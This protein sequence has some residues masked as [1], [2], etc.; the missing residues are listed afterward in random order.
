MFSISLFQISFFTT[1]QIKLML[2]PGAINNLCFLLT[3]INIE[4]S[5]YELKESHILSWLSNYGVVESNI[6]EEAVVLG[7]DCKA[8]QVGTGTYLSRVSLKRRIPNVVPMQGKKIR[9]WYQG[10]KIQCRTCYGHHKRDVNCENKISFV[11]Y[12]SVFR[13]CRDHMFSLEES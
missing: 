4:G 3:F 6:E 11:S 10:V 2:C 5:N 1:I 9:I 7:E 12:T 8:I 13:E